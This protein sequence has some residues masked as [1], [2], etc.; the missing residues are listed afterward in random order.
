MD[1]ALAARPAHAR[2]Q[3]S[4]LRRAGLITAVIAG[5][6]VL[7]AACGGG[8]GGSGSTPPQ[9]SSSQG[10]SQSGAVAFAQCVRSHGV[11]DFPDPQNGHFIITSHDQSNPNFK[12][13]VQAC[14]H[15]LG[16]G[17]AANSGSN[18][19]Q[20]LAFAHCMQTHGVPQF[21]DPTANGGIMGGSGIDPNSPQFRQAYQ[22]CQSLLP[23]N[24]QGQQP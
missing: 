5:L 22:Q 12:P 20:L 6:A 15:L 2:R 16:P 3:G 24:V 7:L 11:S 23:G 18:N 8:S 9:G 13:A 14:Q 19:S 1:K 4:R 10:S 17:G 21:P